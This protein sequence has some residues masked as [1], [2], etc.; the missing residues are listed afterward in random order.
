M[1]I[2]DALNVGKLGLLTSQRAVSV[3]A[4][5]VA[6]ASTPGY[7]RQRAN[8]EPLRQT[9]GAGGVAQGGGVIVGEV[10]RLV[11]QAL[12]HQL[13]AET[14][15]QSRQSDLETG[16]AR[17]EAVLGDLAG[18]GIS[19]ALGVFFAS[20]ED[21]A[22]APESSTARRA[23]IEGARALVERIAEADQRLVQI[24][25]DADQAIRQGAI[26]V[27][28]I[29]QDIADLDRQISQSEVGGATASALRDQR[30]Q[31]LRELAGHVDFT[32]LERP[33]GSFAVYLGSGFPLVEGQNAAQLV[34]EN[35][36]PIPLTEPGFVNLFF[37]RSGGRA[38]PITDQIRGGS[39]AAHTALR[40]D[41][42]P[43]YRGE[44]DRLAFT[45]AARVND[46]HLLGA[47]LDDASARN[48]FVDRTGTGP[49][50]PGDPLTQVTGAAGRLAL[51][52]DIVQ[53]PRHLAAG[54]PAAGAAAPGDN[55]NALALAALQG[56]TGLAYYVQG[57]VLGAPSG[58]SG[59]LGSF[60]DAL[61]GALGTEIRGAQRALR[62]SELLIAEVEDRIAS[63]S[64]VSID[65][66]TTQL[67]ALQRAYQANARVIST[68]DEMLQDLLRM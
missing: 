24:Q 4:N 28:R 56:D 68:V 33:D 44:L 36:Q 37:E 63:V 42:L 57:D 38:G 7:T 30:D 52:P 43:F 23:V 67:I 50:P 65:E 62:Q 41:R 54:R 11:D 12:L 61:S 14:Q 19:G 21:L 40:D 45:L 47:G 66:E 64:G 3:V 35:T 32:T 49:N 6:N 58:Q 48:L 51:N 10:Q 22:N 1:S 16:L 31:L 13:Q 59:T 27:S 17:V 5:N 25:N 8:L 60:F 55:Q 26:E 46:V 15:R 2:F 18:S 39:L 34:A 29:A 53:N 20:V 9:L